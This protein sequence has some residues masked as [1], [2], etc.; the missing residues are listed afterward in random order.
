[1]IDMPQRTDQSGQTMIFSVL[2]MFVIFGFL[3][4]VADGGHYLLE[5]RDMQGVADAAAMAGIQELPGS[6]TQAGWV[7]EQ[8]VTV[9]NAVD[10]AEVKLIQTSADEVEVIVKRDVSGFFGGFVGKDTAHI[11]GRAVAKLSQVRYLSPWL[12]IGLMEGQFE[13]GETEAIKFDDPGSNHGALRVYVGENGECTASYGA[14]DWRDVIKSELDTCGTDVGNTLDTQPGNIA[15]PAKQA[16]ADRLD[17]C[18]DEFEDVF[19]YNAETGMYSVLK[20]DSPRLGIVPVVTTLD[21][22]T[23]WPNGSAPVEIVGYTIVWLGDPDNGD[24][25]VANN[26]KTVW[27]VPIN[28]ELPDDEDFEYLDDYDPDNPS[29]VS[30]RLVE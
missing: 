2:F 29:P 25:V 12:P 26:G 11:E 18:T 1:M 23:T 30:Y 21:G 8:Y 13:Y 3:G 17:G 6:Q 15:G 22:G 27:A 10:E 19:E 14:N 16:F 9:E 5:R 20:W 28:A 24:Q 7:A 4:L